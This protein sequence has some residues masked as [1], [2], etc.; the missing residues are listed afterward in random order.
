[1]LISKY[2]EILYLIIIAILTVSVIYY[3]LKN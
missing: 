1:M 2:T 3:F